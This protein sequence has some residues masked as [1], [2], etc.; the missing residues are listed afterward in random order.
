MDIWKIYKLYKQRSVR[1]PNDQISQKITEI[2]RPLF[3]GRKDKQNLISTI[4]D[5]QKLEEMLPTRLKRYGNSMEA[6]VN[7]GAYTLTRPYQIDHLY[8]EENKSGTIYV[9]SSPAR[10]GQIKLGATTMNIFDR[11]AKYESKYGYKVKPEKFMTVLKPF[12]LENLVKQQA[13]EN[14]VAGNAW[15][16]SI[17]WYE[18]PPM[19]LWNL[20]IEANAQ[21]QV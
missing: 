13:K 20:V 16:D 6:S 4:R 2:C 19:K 15:G 10:P 12:E 8:K 7:L 14:R 11:C 5:I 18:L 17:E 9:L 21:R 1:N 3:D